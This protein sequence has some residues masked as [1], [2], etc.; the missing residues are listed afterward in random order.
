MS[1]KS[2]P[3]CDRAAYADDW[4]KV[5][6]IEQTA[7]PTIN[8]QLHPAKVSSISSFRT[9]GAAALLVCL[10]CLTIATWVDSYGSNG[11]DPLHRLLKAKRAKVGLTDTSDW[12]FELHPQ[13]VYVGPQDG[14][15]EADKITKLPGQPTNGVSF[16]QYSGYVTVDPVHGRALFYYFAESPGNASTNPLVL[17]LNGGISHFSLVGGVRS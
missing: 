14:S 2:Q 7:H 16:D 1:Q 5:I 3:V 15:M 12:S 17:W 9:M 6:S 11:Y 8:N 4:N 13:D 10:T